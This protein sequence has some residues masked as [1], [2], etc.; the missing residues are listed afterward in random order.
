MYEENAYITRDYN[1][2]LTTINL[3]ILVRYRAYGESV[4]PFADLGFV[5]G[6][7]AES[8]INLVETRYDVDPVEVKEYNL[9]IIDKTDFGLAAGVGLD[10]LINHKRTI[11]IELRYQFS[12]GM[13]GRIDHT[14][15]ALELLASYNF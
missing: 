12:F 2:S 4:V 6:L 10:Y 1:I 5:I 11:G 14:I 3:P 8:D 13:E 7:N 15:Q 9:E